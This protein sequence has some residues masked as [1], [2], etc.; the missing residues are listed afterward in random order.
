MQQNRFLSAVSATLLLLTVFVPVASAV[1]FPDAAGTVYDSAFSY[2]SDR[3]II[4]G[5][6]D[7]YGRPDDPLNRAEAIK[8]V[9]NLDSATQTRVTWF[10]SHMPPLSL[11]TDVSQSEWYAPSVE[12]AFEKSL[13]TG[14]PDGSFRPGQLLRVEEAVA[15]LMRSVNEGSG[16]NSEAADL[17]LYIEN[18]GSEWFTSAINAAI[19]KNLVMHYGR[20]RLNDAITRGQF[21]DMAYR[22]HTIRAGNET[23]YTGHEPAGQAPSVPVYSQGAVVAADGTSY[24]SEKYFAIS[25]PSLGIQDLTITH[26]QDPFSKDGIMEPL[27]YGVGHLFGYPGAGGKAMIYGHSS[28]YPWDLSQYT[29]I[30]RQINQLGQGDRV[31]VTFAGTIYTY[32][33][34]YHETI[35]AADTAPFNDNGSGEELILYT[36]WP[37]DSISQRYLVHA[38]PVGAVA[39]R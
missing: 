18:R 9:L 17:S 12:A 6:P 34:T 5:Y 30:F 35:D 25:M 19:R 33:V 2:L 16:T 38:L 24:G 29:K 39:A 7:G 8:V 3:N 15:L 22:L 31:Y 28:G 4:Q 10:Q 26:P 36:C 13:I 32:E 23:A 21:F 1:T 37:P 11:F 20:L 14:Y 27:Q